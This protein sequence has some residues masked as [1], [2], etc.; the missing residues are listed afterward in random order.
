MLPQIPVIRLAD[1]QKIPLPAYAESV[2]TCMI[3]RANEDGIKIDPNC[4]EIFSTGI[5]LALPIG[6]EAQVRSLKESTQ[7]GGSHA[8]YGLV[9]L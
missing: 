3:L 7:T 1:A 8:V 6:M 2:G 5:V 4:S 9:R